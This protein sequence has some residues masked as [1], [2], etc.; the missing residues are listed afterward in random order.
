MSEEQI[1]GDVQ[2]STPSPDEE[3]LKVIDER[4]EL[5]GQF[6]RTRAEFENYRKRVQREIEEE[7]KYQCGSTV[8][9]LLPGL[10]NLVRALQAARDG[11]SLENLVTGIDLVVKQFETLLG[12]LGVNVIPAHDQAFDPNLHEAIQQIPSDRPAMTVVQ[13]VQ[14]GYQLHDRVLRPS[15]VIVSSGPPAAAN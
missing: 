6:L 15:Q 3:L 5:R 12:N 11:G 14:R 8:R 4:E 13:E 2:S 7:R 1:P 9:T 10:D